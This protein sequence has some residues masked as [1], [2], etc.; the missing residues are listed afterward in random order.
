MMTP[1]APPPGDGRIEAR[2]TDF[3]VRL[4]FLGLFA[5]WSL[6]LVR[7]FLPI[8][9]WAILLAVALYPA[10]AGLARWLGGRRGLAATLLT[11]VALATVLGPV[12][13]LAASLVDSV[14]WLAEGLRTGSLRVPPPPAALKDW[15]VLGEPVDEAWKLAAGN[16]DDAVTRYGPALLPAGGVVLGKIAAI[17]VDVVKFVASVVIAG[18]LFLPGPRLATGARAF[19]SRLIAPRGAQFVDLAGATIRNV[20]RGVIGVALLQALLA[21]IILYLAGI[22][23][24]GLIAFGVLLLCVVQ[25]GPAPV[26][27]PVLIWI[28]MTH[29]TTFALVITLLLLPVALLDNVLKPVLMARGLTTPMLVILTGVIGGT[30]THGLVGLFLG[31]VVLSVFY[32]LVVAW[33]RLGAAPA[34]PGDPDA[35]S[36]A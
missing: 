2:A 12:S 24:A 30:L 5:W 28:W 23:G 17:G 1:S 3:A 20:S 29:A 14:H 26:L 13:V 32:D 27:L 9:I 35:S 15:P 8:V 21:G 25:I 18:F 19:A 34:G 4:A 11:I 22:P 33:T 6:D 31:P 10:Y 7:P 36:G 16:L